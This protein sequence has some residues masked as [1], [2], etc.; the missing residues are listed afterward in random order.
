MVAPNKIHN[1]ALHEYATYYPNA[2]IFASPGLPERKPDINFEAVLKD[3]PE[4]EWKNDI[5][6]TLT[7]GNVFFS[8]AIFYHKAS[9]TLL[10]CDFVENMNKS[11]SSMMLLFKLFGVKEK[12]MASPEF[13]IYTTNE[14]DARET[15]EKVQ[16]WDFERIFLCHGD[17]IVHDAKTIF[18]SVCSEY[19][20]GVKK[21]RWLSKKVAA[22]A[23]KLQ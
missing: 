13:R 15:L 19:L 2:K 22:I 9:K 6:Q 4:Q 17:I 18:S 20:D 7:K 12:P 16:A 1:Q 10:V 11:T 21:M 23:A 5:E 14:I 3:E 8:E